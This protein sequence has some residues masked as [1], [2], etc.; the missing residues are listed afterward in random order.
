[1][2][3]DYYNH[4]AVEYEEI[5]HRQDPVR[6]KEQ[7]E[8]AACMKNV[9]S[10]RCV[11]EIACGTGFWTAIVAEVAERVVAIDISDEMLAVAKAKGL[12]DE[13]VK[14]CTAD[15]YSLDS[16]KKTFDAG[17]ANFWL[18]H[19]SKSQLND[20][21]RGFHKKLISGAVVFMA[22]NIYVP[23]IGGELIKQSG[24]EDTFK[25]RELSDGSR[26]KVLKNYYD[27][28]QLREIFEPF[29]SGLKVRMGTCFWWLSYL[30]A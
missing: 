23:G 2:L 27:E 25:L 24:C 22:D 19:V 3:N 8:I 12:S 13:K 14:F 11:L 30:V 16:I 17:L 6:Q 1:M 10:N 26:Y 21:L 15:A 9:L 20:F 5:Y 28:N 29:S 7:V 18:S 4:R